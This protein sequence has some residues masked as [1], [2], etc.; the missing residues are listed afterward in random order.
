MGVFEVTVIGGEAY[1]RDDWL[2]IVRAIRD[3]GMRCS[4]TTGGRGITPE[5]ARGDSLTCAP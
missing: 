4:M 5:L 1:L 2:Q 3:G